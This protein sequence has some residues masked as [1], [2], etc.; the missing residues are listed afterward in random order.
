MISR[1]SSGSVATVDP[2]ETTSAAGADGSVVGAGIEERPAQACAASADVNGHGRSLSPP[3]ESPRSSIPVGLCSTGSGAAP[4]DISVESSMRMPGIH[5][6]AHTVSENEKVK[7]S[8]ARRPATERTRRFIQA[9][10]TCGAAVGS[11]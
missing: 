1:R 2:T 5:V 6:D 10:N 4:S 3:G 7:A 8:R 9:L 11:R